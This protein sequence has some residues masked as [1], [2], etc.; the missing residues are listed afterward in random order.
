MLRV[1]IPFVGQGY[2]MP[3]PGAIIDPP[4]QVRAH[5][6]EIGV[7]EVYEA[8]IVR[9]PPEVKKEA[10]KP[11]GS[12]PVAQVSTKATSRRSKKTAKK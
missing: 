3:S 9:P 7:A 11:L 12:A 8:K 6:I 10:K 1:L 4:A 5:L 2:N